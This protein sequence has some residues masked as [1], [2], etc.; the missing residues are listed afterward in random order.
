MDERSLLLALASRSPKVPDGQGWMHFSKE[1][2]EVNGPLPSS[3]IPIEE[4][5]A[6]DNALFHV[7]LAVDGY[8]YGE[9]SK[10]LYMDL[11]SEGTLPTAYSKADGSYLFQR[12]EASR[13]FERDEWPLIWA[14]RIAVDIDSSLAEESELKN[15]PDLLYAAF[16]LATGSGLESQKGQA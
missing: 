12:D 3:L 9:D 16:R 11:T 2:A 10:K 7:W 4:L 1:F 8:Q 14:K 5:N 6:L 13:R 15:S